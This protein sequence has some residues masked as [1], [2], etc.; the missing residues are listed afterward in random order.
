ML[1]KVGNREGERG[2]SLYV[3]SSDLKAH[4]HGIGASRTGKSK[5][6]ESIVRQLI[7]E[8]QGFCLLDPG[9]FL[10]QDL[11]QW[12]AYTRPQR[13]GPL[14]IDPSYDRRI[15]GFNPLHISGPKSES[16][17]S[18]KVD[19]LVALTSKALGFSDTSEAPRRERIIRCLYY[20]LI[21]Q[22]LPL[23]ALRYF[24][25]P[26]HFSTRDVLVDRIKSEAI[27]DEW[28][29]LTRR[30]DES[31]RNRVE[32]SANRLCQIL[33]SPYIKRLIGVPQNSIDI[34]SAINER[35]GIL[36]NLQP[37]DL[38]SEHASRIVGTF[39]VNQIWETIRKRTRE[40][41][42][43]APHFYLIVDEFQSFATPDF[44]Q[45]LDQAA[46]YGLH[47]LLFNQN[48][49]QLDEKIR[50][51]MTACH[52]RFVFGGVTGSDAKKMLEGSQGDPEELTEFARI[53][54]SLRPRFYVLKRPEKAP[55]LAYTPEVHEYRIS[56]SKMDRYLEGVTAPFLSPSE[57][58][59]L[60]EELLPKSAPESEAPSKPPV[61]DIGAVL[62]GRSQPAR[63][64][65]NGQNAKK[66]PF[67]LSYEKARGTRQHRELQRV[68]ESIASTYGFSTQI[69]K[70]V[71]DGAGSV[72]VSLERDRKKIACEVS[73]TT[74]DAWE[75]KN[76]LK[77][78]KAGYDTVLVVASHPKRI[79]GITSKL[80]AAVP[81]IEQARIKV[82]T[83]ADSL[84]YLRDV[85]VPKREGSVKLADARLTFEEAM[86]FFG[87]SRST[88]SRWIQAGKIP[89]QRV[90]RK[91]RFDRD[92][93]IAIGRFS[94]TG[95]R[96]PAVDLRPIKID[97]PKPASK[98]TQDDRYRKML[99]LD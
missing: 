99:D 96:K 42:R 78:L 89:C 59:S 4:A 64:A 74:S 87:V 94:L 13:S 63:S 10:Y 2:E 97:K 46:K 7:K 92:D 33:T 61:S 25:T 53:V 71:L 69:E 45:M 24:L 23:E 26:R 68:V 90:G 20:V 60:I 40:E 76:V 32:S 3:G 5:L 98:K 37:S 50:T 19:R 18:A 75:V 86:E 58:D 38:L 29:D 39:L 72:D 36:V 34:P 57:L 52:T 67:V 44:A 54:P 82:L 15:V 77:C 49:D 93:L 12:L 11:V 56:Q 81:V 48:V 73:V 55:A 14:L 70:T 17:I 1:L 28:L 84:A 35:R 16:M 21:E 9:G 8:R 41:I 43:T 6:I 30:S 83:L 31:Y 65:Q 66:R 51:A 88:L 62:T 79:P 22:D 80:K 91:Y 47:L 27:K 95:K 85:A